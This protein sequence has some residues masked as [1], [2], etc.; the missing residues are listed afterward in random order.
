MLRRKLKIKKLIQSFEK[1]CL[2]KAPPTTLMFSNNPKM[3]FLTSGRF[4]SHEIDND[5]LGS[6][7]FK[8]FGFS[9]K[10]FENQVDKKIEKNLLTL[11]QNAEKLPIKKVRG[12][13][14]KAFMTRSGNLDKRRFIKYIQKVFF[15]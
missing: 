6:S 2:R 3:I 5:E 11:K 7:K 1:N 13:H 8:T 14:I 9:T 10:H 15:S 12:L 4:F